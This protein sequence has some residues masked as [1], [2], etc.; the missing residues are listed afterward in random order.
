MT[1]FGAYFSQFGLLSTPLGFAEKWPIIFCGLPFFSVG[2]TDKSTRNRGPH[3][4]QKRKSL[5]V[6]RVSE[7]RLLRSCLFLLLLRNFSTQRL[8][9]SNLPPPS[10]RSRCGQGHFFLSQLGVHKPVRRTLFWDDEVGPLL[11]STSSCPRRCK[12]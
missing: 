11:T 1:G 5:P 9:R 6:Y 12:P 2:E 3:V 4:R 8:L 7:K 10:R